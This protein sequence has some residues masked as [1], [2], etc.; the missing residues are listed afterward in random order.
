MPLW[1]KPTT[2]NSKKK[3]NSGSNKKDSHH[4]N[5]KENGDK[6]KKFEEPAIKWENSKAKRLL[7][8]AIMDGRV[9][10]ESKGQDELGLKLKLN[11]TFLSIPE[12]AEYDYKKLSLQLSSLCKTIQ[13]ANYRAN[14]DK[15]A[16]ETFKANNLLAIYTHKGYLQWHGSD[17]KKQ[18]KQ[19]I[20]DGL[21]ETMGKKELWGS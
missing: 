1:K 19:D 17:A 21:L 2:N 4:S 14:L 9:P 5:K 12:L 20:L 16:F 3:G 10:V 8:E 11:D 15:K 13:D 6:K 18:L 7:Y